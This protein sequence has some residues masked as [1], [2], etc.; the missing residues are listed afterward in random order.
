MAARV[1]GVRMVLGVNS[2][3]LLM[4]SML[5]GCIC[6]E[7]VSSF[8][9]CPVLIDPSRVSGTYIFVFRL[10]VSISSSRFA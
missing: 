5:A 4:L 10:R 3:L 9:C 2:A 8:T 7:A 1:S 6:P